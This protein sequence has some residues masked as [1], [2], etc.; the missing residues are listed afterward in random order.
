MNRSLAHA[1]TEPKPP[2][3][4]FSARTEQ[5]IASVRVGDDGAPTSRIGCVSD[6]H[7]PRDLGQQRLPSQARGEACRGHRLSRKQ[8]VYIK[9]RNCAGH[10]DRS[11]MQGKLAAH[12]STVDQVHAADREAIRLEVHA[13]QLVQSQHINQGRGYNVS[14]AITRRI[15]DNKRNVRDDQGRST[16]AAPSDE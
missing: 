7:M 6:K 5:E 11:Q 1:K 2:R 9:K 3:G 8:K 13:V 10:V 4:P 15:N 14:R 12:R 16:V